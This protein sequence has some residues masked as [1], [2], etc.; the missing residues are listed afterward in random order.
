[1]QIVSFK[2]P[3]VATREKKGKKKHIVNQ[4]QREKKKKNN[5]KLS[6]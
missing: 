1:M 4:I 3:K 2:K 5:T 6:R